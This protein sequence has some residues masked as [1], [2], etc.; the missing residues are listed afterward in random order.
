MFLFKL[1]SLVFMLLSSLNKFQGGGGGKS[2]FSHSPVWI[3]ENGFI[4]RF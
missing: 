3:P 4:L 2:P 1:I